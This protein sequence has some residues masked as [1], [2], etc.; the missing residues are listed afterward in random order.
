[1]GAVVHFCGGDVIKNRIDGGDLTHTPFHG[2]VTKE[3]M[4]NALL[5]KYIRFCIIG[6]SQVVDVTIGICLN[7]KTQVE[8]R[9]DGEI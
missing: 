4:N 7:L 5:G 9:I 3:L 1:M 2:L 6:R 8:I